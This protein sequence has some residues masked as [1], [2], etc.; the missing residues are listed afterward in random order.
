LAHGAA[1]RALAEGRDETKLR[2]EAFAYGFV[3]NPPSPHQP[4]F[5][6]TLVTCAQGDMRASASGVTVYD[7]NGMREIPLGGEEVM[8]GR[9]EVLDDM[10]LAI[11]S[12][13]PPLHDGRWGKATVEV[14]L[15]M[16]RSAR[17]RREI[18]LEHQVA[19]P[20]GS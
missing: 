3:A 18:A 2:T 4:H 16:L 12:G 10:Y 6:V 20:A 9:R 19:V 15:A 13:R 7:R 14:A 1:R 17:E 11:R 5:G 8:P